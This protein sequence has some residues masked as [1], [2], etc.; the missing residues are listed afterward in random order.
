MNS[1]A[2]FAREPTIVGSAGFSTT[3]AG[4]VRSEGRGRNDHPPARGRGAAVPC[5]RCRRTRGEFMPWSG[6]LSGD[7]PVYGLRSHGLER[8]AG[9]TTRFAQPPGG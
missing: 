9:R 5:F 6:E 2:E 8:K 1:T 7:Y 3:R 4:G